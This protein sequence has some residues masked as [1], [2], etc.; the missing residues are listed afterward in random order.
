MR[1]FSGTATY[2]ASFDVPE[3]YL[4]GNRRLYLD[5]GE[6]KNFAQVVVNGT[7]HPVLWKSPFRIDITNAARAG[8]NTLQIRV[9]NLLPNRMI[10]DQLLPEAQRITW[11][12]FDP[13]NPQSTPKVDKLPLRSGLLGPVIIRP[14]EILIPTSSAA[15]RK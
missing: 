6:V 15:S 8:T 14:A 12:S 9:T 2:S 10:G 11:A 1:Y 7:E 13:F 4:A 5:L 3:S